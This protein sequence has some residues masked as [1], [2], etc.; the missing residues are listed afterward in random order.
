[1]T[2]R[3]RRVRGSY[4]DAEDAPDGGAGCFFR[5]LEHI[6]WAVHVA[7]DE[8]DLV[9]FCGE[10]LR[11]FRVDVSG[12]GEDVEVPVLRLRSA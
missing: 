6:N 4:L 12:Q 1:M 9:A 2:N 11:R 5:G 3:A 8:L 7:S 10:L